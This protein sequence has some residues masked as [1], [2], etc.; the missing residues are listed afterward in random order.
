MVIKRETKQKKQTVLSRLRIGHSNLI[1][2]KHH[3]GFCDHSQEPKTVEHKV[4]V[5][6]KLAPERQNLTTQLQK[7]GRTEN[8]I[9][10]IFKWTEC[11][12]GRKLVFS[13]FTDN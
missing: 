6:R 3:T 10:G 8:N 2:G 1:I 12:Q 7:V 4:T 11:D 5:C 13:F 9:K